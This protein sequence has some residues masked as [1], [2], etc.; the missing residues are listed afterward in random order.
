MQGFATV[1]GQSENSPMPPFSPVL[2]L[3]FLALT[4][5]FHP[6]LV[7]HHSPPSSS[8][9]SNPVIASEYY[10]AAAKSRLSGNLGD[11]LGTPDLDRVQ[12][13]LML[14]LHDWGNCQGQKAWVSLGVAIRYAQILGF[15]YERD[16][17]D[18]P[19]ALS[20][21]LKSEADR[22]GLEQHR[23]IARP[24]LSSSEEFI[25]QE[26]QRRTFWSCFVLDRY[27][28]SGKY[29]P[30]MLNVHDLR[31]QLPSTDR[32]FLF[33]EKVRT[34]LLGEEQ[35]DTDARAEAQSKR[36]S[37]TTLGNGDLRPSPSSDG[38]LHDDTQGAR[39]E[40]STEEGVLSR[41]IRVID[42]YGKLVRWSCGGGRR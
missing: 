11:G 12:A 4:A 34:L 15:Q 21:A 26:I 9:P 19:H 35:G 25:H 31:I 17:D 23:K 14:V 39:W 10:A 20:Q 2:L 30:Q 3:S 42:L 16:L 32:A 33:G 6:Q 29:R 13:L 28:S 37:S 7:A 1:Q 24:S 27:I 18:E 22:M 40:I 5:R 36:L 8:R 41:Y 38:R